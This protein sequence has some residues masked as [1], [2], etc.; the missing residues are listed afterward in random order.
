MVNEA[1]PGHAQPSQI[2]SYSDAAYARATSLPK[3]MA[4]SSAPRMRQ[5][6]SRTQQ[7]GTAAM[8]AGKA[9][10]EAGGDEPSDAAGVDST[11]GRSGAALALM[12][13]VIVLWLAVV[14][15]IVRAAALAPDDAGKVFVLFPPGTAPAEAFAA[16]VNAGGAPI[17]PAVGDWAWIA[18]GDVAGFVGRLETQGALAAFR[19]TPAGLSLAGCFGLAADPEIPHDPFARALAARAA[20]TDS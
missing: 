9:R 8:H 11:A 7:H 16:I 10:S 3:M 6:E 15:L 20:A 2:I 17:R 13:A 4:V 5:D 19:G 18:H 12:L 14:A 1:L